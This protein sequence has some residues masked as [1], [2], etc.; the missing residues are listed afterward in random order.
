MN[1][2]KEQ[3]YWGQGLD[4]MVIISCIILLLIH[5]KQ[6]RKCN[7]QMHCIMQMGNI[8]YFIGMTIFFIYM[9]VRRIRDNY[10]ISNREYDYML[11]VLILGKILG[12]V[13]TIYHNI[14]PTGYWGPIIHLLMI[15]WVVVGKYLSK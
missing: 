11:V 7:T 5:V 1:K 2:E 6:L 14:C 8:L 10:I 13:I 15:A 12:E 9:V 4:I 3:V